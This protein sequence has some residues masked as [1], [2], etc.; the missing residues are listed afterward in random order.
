MHNIAPAEHN[1]RQPKIFDN[2]NH[3]E[4]ITLITAPV[5]KIIA[6]KSFVL[7]KASCS[8]AWKR[9]RLATGTSRLAASRWFQTVT[10]VIGNPNLG[11]WTSIQS[12]QTKDHAVL[13]DGK[14]KTVPKFVWFYDLNRWSLSG[15]PTSGCMRE[16]FWGN[17]PSERIK[18]RGLTNLL[19]R[20]TYFC[21]YHFAPFSSFFN[22]K[23][24]LNRLHP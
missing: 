10:A 13:D 11:W 19:C 21:W 3:G 4:M 15:I 22:D 7:G 6:T 14:N 24:T 16:I 23:P 12:I 5:P 18:W 9:R 2:F 17:Q 8:C 20:M 1:L